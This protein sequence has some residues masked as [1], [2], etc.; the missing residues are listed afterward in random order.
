MVYI[1]AMLLVAGAFVGVASAS[2]QE[3]VRQP[4]NRAA[5]KDEFERVKLGLAQGYANLD[6]QVDRRGLNLQ[7][8]SEQIHAMLDR[9]NSDVEAA[10][11][12]TKLVHAFKDPH[13]QLQIGSPPES[14][15]LLPKK[16][17]VEASARSEG[18]CS[19]TQSSAGKG[20]T[21]LPYPR[22]EGW[23]QISSGPFISGVLG[24]VG[25]LRIPSFSEEDYPDSRKK[26]ARPDMNARAVQLATRAELNRQLREQIAALRGAGTRKLVIDVTGNGGGSEWSSE[27]AA[28]FASGTLKRRAPNL[29]DPSCDR[30]SVWEGKRPCSIYGK[31]PETE[32]MQGKG[33][34]DGPL[35]MLTD[36][37]SASATE[38]LVT[39][40]KDNKRAVIAGERTFGAG[41]GYVDGGYAI[42]LSV[43]NL[44]IMVPNCSRYT[45]E[46]VNEI[47][48]IAPDVAAD[49]ATLEPEE[50]PRLL[51]RIFERR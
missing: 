43:A 16:G 22:A 2:E 8:V 6:W 47:E 42:A 34:W 48:G 49:W 40:L 14:A 28:M 27:V 10:V 33:A 18:C 12:F 45:S 38:E 23:K 1:C 31:A 32:E 7:R 41:C 9:A 15:T 24:D 21:R 37:R 13:L 51:K 44:H 36:R 35:A 39:W 26:V 17:N 20:E 4:F 30:S 25:F 3:A 11:V 50:V 19:A 46:G 5:W 29:A